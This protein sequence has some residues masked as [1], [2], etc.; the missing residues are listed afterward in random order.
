MVEDIIL[1]WEQANANVQYA[2]VKEPKNV[3]IAMVKEQRNVLVAMEK[4]K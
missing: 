2:M 3:R 4:A 1:Q